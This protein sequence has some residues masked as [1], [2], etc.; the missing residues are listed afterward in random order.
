MPPAPER[1]YAPRRVGVVEIFGKA[2]TEDPPETDRHIAVARKIEIDLQGIR[3]GVQPEIQ[4]GFFLRRLEG[5]HKRA[6]H[7]GEQNLFGKPEY[8]PAHAGR[9]TLERVDPLRKLRLDVRIPDDRPRDKLREHRDIN[10]EADKI[11]LR[12]HAAVDVRRIA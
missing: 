11:F 1:G 8:K 12:G 9:C 10:G 4:D 6:E 5:L 3:G 2:K 7:V